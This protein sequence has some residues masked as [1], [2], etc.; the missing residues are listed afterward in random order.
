M[1]GHPD[2]QRDFA[3]ALVTGALP[4]GVTARDPAEAQRR[5]NVYR[6][7]VSHSLTQA[8][9]A[10][11]PVIR[12]L[13][14]DAFFAGMAR[15][16]AD[17]HR[18]KSPVL[19]LW[20]E[21]FPDFLAAFPPLAAYPY[22]TDVARIEVARGVAYHA[23]DCTPLAAAALDAL[24]AAGGDG[25]LY[26]HPSVQVITSAH[27][28]F[29]LWH[30]HQPG[31]TPGSLAGKGPECALILRDRTFDVTVHAIGRDAAAMIAALRAGQTLLAAAALHPTHDPSPLLAL[32]FQAGAL[33]AAQHPYPE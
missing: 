31:Q 18:P 8:L 21:A 17:A 10:K 11:F 9:A 28:A 20:G 30:G 14:G 33:V 27:P 24:A 15:V 29:T 16:F 19:M 22:M 13:V 26:L 32:L 3:D 12:R 25:P 7:N 4:G 1:P 2:L 5:F 6:N 23:A